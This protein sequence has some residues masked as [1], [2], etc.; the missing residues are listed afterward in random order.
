[1]MPSVAGRFADER[2]PLS[3][4][5]NLQTE[6]D[7]DRA[8]GGDTLVGR[9]MVPDSRWASRPQSKSSGAGKDARRRLL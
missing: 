5:P 4:V 8:A 6:E 3:R 1:M 7:G 9:T 2:G